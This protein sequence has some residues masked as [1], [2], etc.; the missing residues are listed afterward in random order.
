M[1]YRQIIEVEYREFD[2]TALD[3][4]WEWLNDPEIR[5]LT[6][7]PELDKEGQRKWF[8]GLKDR[9]DYF[10][11]ALWH[12]NKPIAIIGLK[13][14]NGKDAELFGYIGDKNYWGK[15]IGYH[16]MMYGIEHARSLNLESVYT[17]LLKN[18]IQSYKIN[19][20]CGLEYEKDFEDDKM[21]MRLYL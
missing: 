1:E 14:I 13:N 19:R 8:E 12:D 9:K 3:K 5:R 11:E 7:T 16:G 2:E 10:I 20:R 15:A 6:I 4:T 21:I 17:I 18:N